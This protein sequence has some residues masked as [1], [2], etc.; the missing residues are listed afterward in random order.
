MYFLLP[1]VLIS[2]TPQPEWLLS[3]DEYRWLMEGVEDA[4]LTQLQRDELEVQIREGTKPEC[5]W[6]K[7]AHD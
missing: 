1:L 7:D 6:T 4:E 2:T 5:F 3:C